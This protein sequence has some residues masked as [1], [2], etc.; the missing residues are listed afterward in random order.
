MASHGGLS[1]AIHT[2]IDGWFCSI[3]TISACCCRAAASKKRDFVPSRV[4]DVCAGQRQVLEHQ[5]ARFV[6]ETVE[7]L[8]QHVGHDAKCVEVRLLGYRDVRG[9]GLPRVS[10]S[11]RYEG[12]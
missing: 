1:C 8:G 2:A 12:A 11:S 3:A 5:H 10:S 7:V 4:I 9:E 6:G